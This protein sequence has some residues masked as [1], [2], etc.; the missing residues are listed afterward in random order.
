MKGRFTLR[1]GSLEP[2][3]LV[4]GNLPEEYG[5]VA[6]V[7]DISR[8]GY[9]ARLITHDVIE[10]TVKHRTATYVT[11]EQE[12][13]ALGAAVFVRGAD[14]TYDVKNL[15]EYVHRDLVQPPIIYPDM[16]VINYNT[17]ECNPRQIEVIRNNLNFGWWVKHN[18]FKGIKFHAEDAFYILKYMLEKELLRVDWDNINLAGISVSFDTDKNKINIR[19]KWL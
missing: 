11:L 10:H 15:V 9:N 7:Y 13:R 4:W 6:Y 2:E 1:L 18:Q 17:L 8:R 19:R 5:I 16:E 12:L 3:A 14:P